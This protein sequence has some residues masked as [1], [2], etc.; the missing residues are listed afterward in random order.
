MIK[1]GGSLLLFKILLNYILGFINI[2]VEG[3]F[4]E[5]FINNCISN[6]VFLWRIK[7]K[8]STILTANINI[9]DFKK[10]RNISRKTKCKIK[11]N[12]KNGL[13]ILI[14]KYR[15]RKLLLILIIPIVLAI[16]ISSRFIWNVE[17]EGLENINKEEII[18][19]LSNEGVSIGKNKSGINTKKVID[20]I[21]LKR[22]DISWM[23]IDMKGTNVIVKIVEALQKPYIIDENENCNIVANQKGMI[24]KI[25]ADVGTANVKQGD[26]V[27]QGDVLIGGYMEGK[28][29]D[30]RY[31]HAKGEVQAK[32]WYTKKID[33]ETTRDISEKTGN[34]KNKYS[35]NI[36]N[37]KINL[38]KSIP[39]FENYDT[40][41]ETKRIKIFS[42]FYL[43][44]EIN[45]ITYIEKAKKK[46]TYGKEELK[47][48]LIKELEQQ[49][50][51]DGIDKQ[52]VVNKVVN[53]YSKENNIIEVEM[54]YEVIKNIGTEEKIN[55]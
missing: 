7:R 41:D 12:S 8:N 47:D 39:N 48:V 49:F 35:V 28:Y 17:I 9:N 32:V 25:T 6:N 21:R 42:N 26:I 14:H 30:K 45:K 31:V 19:Q 22:S 13:P 18:Y 10:I 34:I 3:F 38:Y 40:I 27:E 1:K 43:P 5:R 23:A 53:I 29:T 16:L 24:V 36:N 11:I 46:I 44:I 33:S 2:T 54:T 4:V 55:F 20:N 52:N 37:F 50:I 51:Q 15:K